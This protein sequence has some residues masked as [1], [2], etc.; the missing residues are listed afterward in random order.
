MKHFIYVNS[1]SDPS[2]SPIMLSHS[3]TVA[4]KEEVERCKAEG[5]D[6]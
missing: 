3:H 5:A 1:S 4:N 2:I 6:V